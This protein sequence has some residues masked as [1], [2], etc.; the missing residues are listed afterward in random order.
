MFAA[1]RI[2]QIQRIQKVWSLKPYIACIFLTWK[3]I[4]WHEVPE[5]RM[6]K[7][8]PLWKKWHRLDE[9][10]KKKQQQKKT[11]TGGIYFVSW[12]IWL[13]TI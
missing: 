7:I 9:I 1:L 4:S 8:T 12:N 11:K 6:K 5:N 3:Y 10:A 2:Q 13:P